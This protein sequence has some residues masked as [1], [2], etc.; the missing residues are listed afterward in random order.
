MLELQG[1]ALIDETGR[2]LWSELNFT[3]RPGEVTAIVGPVGSGKTS[4][5]G[6]ICG[7]TP[8]GW[9]GKLSGK[10]VLVGVD[11]TALKPHQTADRIGL[12]SQNPEHGFVTERVLDELAFGGEQLGI[13]LDELHQRMRDVLELLGLEHLAG[14]KV[15]EISG[16]EKQLIAIASV[17]TSGQQ[18][19]LLD[20]PLARLDTDNRERVLALI[21]N[22]A[23]ERNIAV[24]ITAH[25]E[26]SLTGLVDQVVR[27][28]RAIAAAPVSQPPRARDS[29]QGRDI[30][31][32]T[33][34]ILSEGTPIEAMQ[35]SAAFGAKQVFA[36]LDFSI[37]RGEVVA[38]TGVNGAGKSTLLDCIYN[39]LERDLDCVML[40]Q[41]AADLLM[42]DSVQLE[43]DDSDRVTH[44][45]QGTTLARLNQL[46]FD[47]PLHVHPRDLSAG[48]QLALVLA[49]QLT[50]PAKLL[51]LDE[52]NRALD[53]QTLTTLAQA[54]KAVAAK[55]TAV[56]LVS[57][58]AEFIGATATRVLRLENAR[59]S[60]VEP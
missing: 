30:D 31:A 49:I 4:L 14:R 40:P 48:Q 32:L 6:A 13:N 60:Q 58:D 17:L 54:L 52:P 12:V 8:S 47:L 37:A 41:E 43:L 9:R 39:R 57:H 22:L 56:L 24:V 5:L 53:A 44:S 51:L 18:Y 2:P 15:F 46:G 23:R 3:L 35:L 29:E 36:D 28:N 45:P 27:L 33:R 25:E 42:F 16:G 55:G 21:Q 1:L 10:R 59:L 34:A 20:E 26:S 7:L 50:R 38:L 19:L 11:I